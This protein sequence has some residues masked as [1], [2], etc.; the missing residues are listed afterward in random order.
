MSGKSLQEIEMDCWSNTYCLSTILASSLKYSK[1]KSSF[2]CRYYFDRYSSELAELIPL[3]HSCGRTTCS[4]R[5]HDFSVPIPRC[6]KDIYINS[7]FPGTAR[8]RNSLRAK[9]FLL[10]CDLNGFKTRANRCVQTLASF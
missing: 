7:F 6:Y 2:F 10:T 5:L 4:N 3:T 1:L 8:L 9:L